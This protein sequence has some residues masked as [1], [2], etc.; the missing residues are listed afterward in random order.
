MKKIFYTLISLIFLLSINACKGYKPI[1]GSSNINFKIVD[2]SISGDKKIGN[3][4]YS[5]LYNLSKS[6]TN[7]PKTKN[8]YIL[9]NA[10]KN[11]NATSKNNAGKI[12]GYKIELSTKITIK[13]IMTGSKILNENY[14]FSS[15][16]KVHDLY[17]E[18]LKLENRSIENLINKTYQDLL[19][20]LSENI[21]Q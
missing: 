1:F 11:K 4:I 2:Y 8:I 5:K 17:S 14:V 6:S 15:T 13:D 21:L 19:I 9:I 10:V 12:L 7:T 16:F 18:T 20:K 3:Q